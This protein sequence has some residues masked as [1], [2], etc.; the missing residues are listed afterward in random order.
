MKRFIVFHMFW[1]GSPGGADYISKSFDELKDAVKHTDELI[2]IDPMGKC[3]VYDCELEE[4]VLT[5]Y[6]GAI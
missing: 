1:Y 6:T 2:E 5:V 4:V 3:Q